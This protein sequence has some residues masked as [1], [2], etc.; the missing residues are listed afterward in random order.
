M[1]QSSTPLT[2]VSLRRAAARLAAGDR[3]L[4]AMVRANGAPPLWAR[5]AGFATL[6]RIILEQQVSLASGAAAYRRLSEGVGRVTPGNVLGFSQAQIQSM[7]QT[8]QKA[9]YC[10]E[11][12]SAIDEGRLDLRG[13]DPADPD[14]VRRQLTA[15]TGIGIWTADIYLLMALKHPDI[16]PRGDL[17]LYQ[18][19]RR[20]KGANKTT[21][22]LDRHTN[23]WKP[24]RSVAARILW[25]GYLEEKRRGGG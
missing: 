21:A 14:L 23:N 19:M 22:Q 13:L 6:L 24:Y 17:A 20:F 1:V 15:I 4:A 16:W 5:P 8:R 3:N 18:S 10:R 2:H 7:G 12:A 9:R 25:H 11:L